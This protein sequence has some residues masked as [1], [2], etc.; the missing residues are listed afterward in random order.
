MQYSQCPGLINS[1]ENLKAALWVVCPN[2]IG[3]RANRVVVFAHLDLRNLTPGPSPFLID[4]QHAG[5]L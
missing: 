2:G 5:S 3:K 4:E 1:P